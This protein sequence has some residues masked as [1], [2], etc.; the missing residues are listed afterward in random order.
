[1]LVRIANREDPDQTAS[2]TST[3]AS[4]LAALL[5][6]VESILMSPL[7]LRLY[8]VSKRNKTESFWLLILF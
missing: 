5:I 7:K 1:M 2:S 3:L 8:N 6:L 4:I